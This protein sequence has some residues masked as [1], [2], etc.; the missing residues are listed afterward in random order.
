MYPYTY[1]RSRYERQVL[2]QREDEDSRYSQ[3]VRNEQK[4]QQQSAR[5]VLLYHTDVLLAVR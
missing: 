3:E 5:I 4:R 1:D 2:V